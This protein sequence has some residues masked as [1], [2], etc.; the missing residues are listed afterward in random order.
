MKDKPKL[1]I[2]HLDGNAF[3]I[4]GAAFKALKKA[5][6]SQEEIERY[7]KEATSGDYDNLIQVT[8]DW[9]EVE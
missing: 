6:F 9:F 4:L 8:M 5:G 1:D 7:K 2:S 3:G